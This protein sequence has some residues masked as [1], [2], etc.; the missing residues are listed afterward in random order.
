MI[1]FNC[2]GCLRSFQVD[3][4]MAGRSF[5]CPDC[6]TPLQVPGRTGELQPMAPTG[7]ARKSALGLAIVSLV[8]GILGLLTFCTCGVGII[9][10]LVGVI[11]GFIAISQMKKPEYSPE[12]RGVAVG[13][14]VTSLISIVLAAGFLVLFGFGTLWT[15]KKMDEVGKELEKVAARPSVI[16]S[17]Q[18]EIA[19]NE[20]TVEC[21]MTSGTS[22]IEVE[23]ELIVLITTWDSEESFE[24]ENET[25]VIEKRFPCSK[26]DGRHKGEKWTFKEKIPVERAKLKKYAT[27]VF[28]FRPSA[29]GVD[30]KETAPR[31]QVR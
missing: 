24:P 15:K 10:A 4:S 1:R 14:V 22:L 27:A 29:G 31:I 18:I 12:G 23:G 19:G 5:T 3:P 26:S 11:L 9:P 2:T 30:L 28:R 17:A 20:A 16:L 13:G 25:V 7:P 21:S 8:M 6:K